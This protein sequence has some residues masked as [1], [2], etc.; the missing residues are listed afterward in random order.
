[1]VLMTPIFFLKYE[2]ISGKCSLNNF[3]KKLYFI[4]MLEQ[5]IE[6]YTEKLK[7][8]EVYPG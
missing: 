2:V 4:E 5:F 8:K 6:N 3:L 1:M 7:F